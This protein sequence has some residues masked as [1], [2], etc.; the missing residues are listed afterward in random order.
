[1]QKSRGSRD[2]WILEGKQAKSLNHRHAERGRV[3]TLELDL[4]ESFHIEMLAEVNRSVV[5]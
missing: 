2:C 4:I 3:L 1:M 5:Q